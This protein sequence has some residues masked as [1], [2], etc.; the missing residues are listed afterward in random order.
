MGTLRV[1]LVHTCSMFWG[2]S[3]GTF[4]EVTLADCNFEAIFL[5]GS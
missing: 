1:Q 4:H 2:I 5:H 3:T